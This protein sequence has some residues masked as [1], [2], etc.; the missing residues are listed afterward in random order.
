MPPQ[1]DANPQSDANPHSKIALD[2]I[3]ATIVESAP[4]DADDCTTL[5]EL[6]VKKGKAELESYQ[7][8]TEARKEYAKKIFTLTCAW[9]IGIYVLL[10]LQGFGTNGFRLSDNV[11]L[12]A[13]GS[14]TANIIGVFLIVTRYFFPKK[15]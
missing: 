14:T 1:A 5:E 3:S 9:V 11:L 2:S 15:H 12:A 13:I 10:I 4:K 6:E 8:D 7:S